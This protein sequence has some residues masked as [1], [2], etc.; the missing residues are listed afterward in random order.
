MEVVD[1]YPMGTI[2]TSMGGVHHGGVFQELE[3]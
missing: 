3:L 2:G 1:S